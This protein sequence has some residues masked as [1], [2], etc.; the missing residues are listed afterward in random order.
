MRNQI[1][2]FFSLFSIYSSY[3]FSDDQSWK[4]QDAYIQLS[5]VATQVPTPGTGSLIIGETID[6]IKNFEVTPNRDGIICIIPGKYLIFTS[7]QIATLSRGISGYLDSWFVL[8]GTAISSSNTRQ[9]VT[10]NSRSGLVTNC[11]LIDLKE[12]DVFSVAFLANG[13]NIGLVYIQS[14]LSSEPSVTS[15]SLSAYRLRHPL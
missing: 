12:T 15:Y 11:L 14:S 1:L 8:N 13:P 10:E 4:D 6:L 7:N 3:L 2:I 5:S 9:F